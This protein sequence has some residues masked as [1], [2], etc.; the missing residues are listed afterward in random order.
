MVGSGSLPIFNGEALARR[1][2]VLVTVN[3]RL[4]VLGF[5]AHPE[6]T[7]ES[8]HNASGNW[9]LLDQ[10]AAL[11]WVQDNIAAFGGD[12]GCVTIFGQSAGST[13][14]SALMASPVA[15][16]LFHRAIGQSGGLMGPLRR[17]GGGSMITLSM[18]TLDVAEQLGVRFAETLG[19]NS[20]DE[21][22]TKPAHEIQLSW[23]SGLGRPPRPILDGWVLPDGV[24]ETFSAGRQ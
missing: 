24:N 3:Y 22:R 16:G 15:R 11:R 1:G 12:P 5:L 23:P 20:I 7:C 13:S 18:M 8:S 2:V 14:V 6:L 4:G 19:A 17:S 10:I 21:M 9:G